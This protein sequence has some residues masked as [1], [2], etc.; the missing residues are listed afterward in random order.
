MRGKIG[1]RERGSCFIG[2]LTCNGMVSLIECL[3][4]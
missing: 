1:E 3:V 4:H 2:L